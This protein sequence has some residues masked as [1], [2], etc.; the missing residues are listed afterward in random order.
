[1]DEIFQWLLSHVT[2]FFWMIVLTLIAMIGIVYAQLANFSDTTDQVIARSGGLT[3]TAYQILNKQ[4]S[5]R[6]HNMFQVRLNDKKKYQEK[7]VDYGETVNYQI[8]VKIPI[9]ATVLHGA[10]H[11]SVQT[12]V[13]PDNPP[14]QKQQKTE[15]QIADHAKN[16]NKK[17]A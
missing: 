16:T 6:Y 3:P 4:S 14:K 9:L 11:K 2:M 13:R 1:M 10:G 17:A 8:V 5:Q 7:Q 12:D 15:Q